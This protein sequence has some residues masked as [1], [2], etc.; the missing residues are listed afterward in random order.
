M[1]RLTGMRRVIRPLP[2][3]GFT[4]V[5]IQSKD[6][7]SFLRNKVTKARAIA[8]DDV[9]AKD[10]EQRLLKHLQEAEETLVEVR[11]EPQNPQ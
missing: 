4:L 3:G 10:Q 8:I 6:L 11:N 9:R 5:G 1:V 7:L 2:Y